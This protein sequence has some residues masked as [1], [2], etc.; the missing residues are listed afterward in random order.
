[1]PEANQLLKFIPEAVPNLNS[2]DNVQTMRKNTIFCLCS[3]R[4]NKD[5]LGNTNYSYKTQYRGNYSVG[6]QYHIALTDMVP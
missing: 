6:E 5:N 3:I 2:N 1:M 4:K